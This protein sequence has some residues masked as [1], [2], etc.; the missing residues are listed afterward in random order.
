MTNSSR[1]FLTTAAAAA[2]MLLPATGSW[3]VDEAGGMVFDGASQS[4]VGVCPRTSGTVTTVDLSFHHDPNLPKSTDGIATRTW[5]GQ[6]HGGILLNTYDPFTQQPRGGSSLS[7][8]SASEGGWVTYRTLGSVHTPSPVRLYI[9]AAGNLSPG[10]YPIEIVDKFFGKLG[11]PWDTTGQSQTVIGHV[12]L[13]VHGRNSF[14]C[15]MGRRGWRP[16]PLG[17][18]EE[19]WRVSPM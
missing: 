12:Y 10:T 8:W 1:R 16:A 9:W 4:S 5:H 17:R 2:L 13:V 3:A 18:D 6:Q 14:H 7:P 11:S 19:E 15:D